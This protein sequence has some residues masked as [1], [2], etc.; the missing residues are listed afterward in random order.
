MANAGVLVTHVEYIKEHHD[1]N[2]V[3]VDAAMTDLLRP[4]LYQAWHDIIPIEKKSH[5]GTLTCDVVGGVCE[6][7]DFLGHDRQIAVQAGDL[8]AIRSCGAYGATMSS[9]YNSR[10]KLTEIMV[11][12]ATTHIIRQR[13]SFE[14][15]INNEQLP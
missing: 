15:M 14:D 12:G 7:G 4:A 11:N 5:I 1:K 9:N 13:E 6:S 2:F 3:I 8:L 10:P